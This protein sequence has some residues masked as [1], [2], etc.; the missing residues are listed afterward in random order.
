MR[1]S[2]YNVYKEEKRE[3]STCM[4]FQTRGR[5]ITRKCQHLADVVKGMPLSWDMVSK[6]GREG[7][8]LPGCLVF[9]L[10]LRITSIKEEIHLNLLLLHWI[11]PYEK[12]PRPQRQTQWRRRHSNPG[13]PRE[14][15]WGAGIHLDCLVGHQSQIIQLSLFMKLDH[16]ILVNP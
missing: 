10:L 5:V 9:L 15:G 11:A 14:W 8:R 4:L 3:V 6:K 12:K 7:E 16:I 1:T 13:P 2:T